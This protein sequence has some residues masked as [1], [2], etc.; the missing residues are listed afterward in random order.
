MQFRVNLSLDFYNTSS[1]TE[2]IFKGIID[3]GQYKILKKVIL[4]PVTLSRI[5]VKNLFSDPFYILVFTCVAE[6]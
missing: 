5:L 4:F 3:L 2:T 1:R 6:L